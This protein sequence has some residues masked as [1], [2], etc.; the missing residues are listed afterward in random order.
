MMTVGSYSGPVLN[1]WSDFAKQ[2][3]QIKVG[4]IDLTKTLT[5]MLNQIK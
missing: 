5:L 2:P 4:T 1:I 3:F